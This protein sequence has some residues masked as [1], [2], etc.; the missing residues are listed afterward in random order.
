MCTR[1]LDESLLENVRQQGIK[2]DILPFIDTEPIQTIEVQQEVEQALVKNATVIFTSMNAVEA[3]VNYVDEQPDWQIYC[4][5]HATRQLVMEHFGEEVIAGTAA[6]AAELA[7]L[8]IEDE[9]G[10]EIIFFCGNQRREELPSLLESNGLE[11]TEIMVYHTIA[12]PHKINKVYNGILFFS[13]SAADSFFSANKLNGPTILFAIGATTA[14]TIKK[15]T[16]NK[17]IVS[18]EPAKEQLVEMMV[19]FFKGE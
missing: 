17:I 18:D 8:V 2:I 16:S 14:K 5:G 3:V 10:N 12:V 15:Y 9:P 6:S 11:L 1:P 7:E 19:D 13:P 4:I